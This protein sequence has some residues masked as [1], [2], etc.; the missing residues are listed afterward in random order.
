M[1]ACG[2]CSAIL[3]LSLTLLGRQGHRLHTLL[4]MV[5]L[6]ATA[7]AVLLPFAAPFITQ[8]RIVIS[9]LQGILIGP[10]ISLPALTCLKNTPATWAATAQE[11]GADRP[12]RLRLLW[13]PLL[14]RALIFGL[15]FALLTSTLGTLLLL[16]TSLP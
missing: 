11:L 12:T 6:P 13:L 7:G 4:L 9:F 3:V 14:S 15:L 16:Q 8:S 5:V 10:L 2:I 1:L